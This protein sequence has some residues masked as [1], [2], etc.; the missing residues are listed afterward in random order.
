[1]K[2]IVSLL[3]CV[4]VIFSSVCVIA[5]ASETD[6]GYTKVYTVRV[7]DNSKNKIEIVGVKDTNYVTKGENF[8]F[9]VKYLGSY[10]PDETTVI[11]V[12]PASFPYDLYY[13]D[14]DETEIITLTPNEYGIYTIEDVQ[15]DMYVAVFSVSANRLSGVKDLLVKFFESI[16]HFFRNLFNIAN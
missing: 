16:L 9:T 6:K 11:K 10:R 4:L 1:M 14:N 13:R 7:D 3:L 8:Q 2:K 12:Y 15:E 5:F